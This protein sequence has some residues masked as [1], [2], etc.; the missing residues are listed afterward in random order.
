MCCL[1]G[2]FCSLLSIFFMKYTDLTR[3]KK[4]VRKGIWF[5]S[6]KQILG[7]IGYLTKFAFSL[8]N[9]MSEGRNYLRVTRSFASKFSIRR[10]FEDTSSL[11]LSLGNFQPKY[12]FAVVKCVQWPASAQAR[13]TSLASSESIKWSNFNLNTEIMK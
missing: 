2:Q 3:V 9:K 12:S 5:P 1:I 13:Q 10:S 8:W 11:Y 6:P 7:K 4:T